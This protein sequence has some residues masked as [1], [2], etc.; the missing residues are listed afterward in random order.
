[1][2]SKVTPGGRERSLIGCEVLADPTDVFIEVHPDT[3][4]SQLTSIRLEMFAMLFAPFLSLAVIWACELVQP[5]CAGVV[6]FAR[7][8]HLPF[9]EVN[10]EVALQALG[11]MQIG[12]REAVTA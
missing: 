9:G 6:T 12:S 2:A 11:E 7:T 8:L 1:M 4:M 3:S 5:V 10:I